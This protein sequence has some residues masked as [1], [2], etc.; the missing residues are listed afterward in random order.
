[1]LN[2]ANCHIQQQCIARQC[3][4]NVREQVFGLFVSLFYWTTICANISRECVVFVSFST[5]LPFVLTLFH[6]APSHNVELLF[7]FRGCIM[8]SRFG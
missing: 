7:M 4:N 3:L 8:A 6:I 1:M 5:V 2:P